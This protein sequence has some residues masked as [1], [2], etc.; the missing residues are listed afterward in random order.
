[1]KKLLLPLLLIML[2]AT[3]PAQLIT[4]SS[5][6]FFG[7][8]NVALSGNS[9]SGDPLVTGSIQSVSTSATAV[10]DVTVDSSSDVSSTILYSVGVTPIGT[11]NLTWA[12]TNLSL[13]GYTI[14]FRNAATGTATSPSAGFT[15]S[16]FVK[17]P[18]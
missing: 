1:M 14:T 4:G 6:I 17:Q 3:A 11:S 13:T 7:F 9:I 5:P 10:F 18:D 2:A 12:V 16:V 8:A 15:T